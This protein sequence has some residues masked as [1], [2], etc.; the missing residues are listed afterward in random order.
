MSSYKLVQISDT[1]IFSDPDG[2]MFG[3]NSRRSL[4]QVLAHA[5]RHHAIDCLLATGDLIHDDSPDAYRRLKELLAA[6]DA[7]VY[8][9]P[10]NHDDP[11]LMQQILNGPLVTCRK[12]IVLGAWKILLLDTHVVSSDGGRLS[13]G[14]LDFLERELANNATLHVVVALHHPPVRIGS[15][16]M[17][18]MGL[19]NTKEFFEVLDRYPKV[20]GVLFGHIHQVFEQRRGSVYLL[21][22]PSTS[23]QFMPATEVHMDDPVPPG[24][25]WVTLHPDGS[26]DTGIDRIE[27]LMADIGSRSAGI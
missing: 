19:A 15:P 12:S 2:T 13:P 27:V 21:S 3:V 14:E 11:A 10:G 20:R 8:C 4:E 26:F 17:D 1:H 7:P 22:A 16:W 18:A 23:A 6:L 25:R 5:T 24:Y 9:L